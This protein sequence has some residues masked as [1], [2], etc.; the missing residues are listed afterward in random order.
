M[1]ANDRF[2]VSELGKYVAEGKHLDRVYGLQWGDPATHLKYITE[3]WLIPGARTAQVSLEIGVGG[4]RWVP[5]YVNIVG[6]AILVDGTPAARTAV[7]AHVTKAFDFHV[8]YNGGLP[9]QHS[10]TVDWVWSFDTFVHFPQPL[11]DRYVGEV[12][13]V[14][15][16][17]GVFHLHYA[18]R[19]MK[20]EEK[21]WYEYRDFDEVKELFKSVG[22]A[23][24]PR[25]TKVGPGVLVE[26]IRV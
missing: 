7:S 24:S 12:A 18:V 26:G 1:V 17:G 15:R 21:P 23:Q 16:P 25:F 10:A 9:F 8:S 6:W 3:G 13:R 2:Q 22:L 14:L 11:F 20:A 5:H 19:P 4:G